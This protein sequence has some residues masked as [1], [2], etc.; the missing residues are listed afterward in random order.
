MIVDL[1]VQMSITLT[2]YIAASQ[3]LATGYK[4]AALQAASPYF[5]NMYVIGVDMMIKLIGTC[6]RLMGRGETRKYLVHFVFGLILTTAVAIGAV[7][8]GVTLR[9]W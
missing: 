9:T 6:S 2:I 8:F 3:H 7:L 1:S 5:G 4:L